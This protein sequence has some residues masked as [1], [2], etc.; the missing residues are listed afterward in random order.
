MRRLS[1]SKGDVR[2]SLKSETEGALIYMGRLATREHRR[3]GVV[4][5]Q[6]VCS[7]FPAILC[8]CATWVPWSE[9]R[10]HPRVVIFS[11][12]LWLQNAKLPFVVI[13]KRS[14]VLTVNDSA[15][16]KFAL[17][18]NCIS[19]RAVCCFTILHQ[20]WRIISEYVYILFYF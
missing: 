1:K 20:S 12:E 6:V 11:G 17:N 4:D 9:M 3:C 10:G 2:F 19:G 18:K 15:D 16:V 13:K 5:Q 7:I 8:V 14:N